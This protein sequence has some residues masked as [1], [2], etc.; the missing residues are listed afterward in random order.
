MAK[1]RSATGAVL[2]LLVGI[3]L[4]V[5]GL[6][7]GLAPQ[8]AGTTSCGSAFLPDPSDSTEYWSSTLGYRSNGTFSDLAEEI[9]ADRTSEELLG[10]L[11]ALGAGIP[12]TVLGAVVL[13]RRAPRPAPVPVPSPAGPTVDDLGKLAD[14]YRSGLLTDEEFRAAKRR[15]LAVDGG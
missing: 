6:V 4:V 5:T 11:V 7:V 12:L 1:R 8:Q 15:L 13:R 9:C 2:A 14:L 3:G 10:G